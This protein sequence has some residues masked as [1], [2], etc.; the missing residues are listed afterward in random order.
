MDFSRRTFTLKSSQMHT[1]HFSPLIPP[2]FLSIIFFNVSPCLFFFGLAAGSHF[3]DQS[4]NLC[5]L[6]WQAAQ[7]LRHQGSP[8]L[9]FLNVWCQSF[10]LCLGYLG[11]FVCQKSA[12]ERQA[13]TASESIQ[14]GGR[15]VWGPPR[16]RPCGRGCQQSGSR[17]LVRGGG[18]WSVAEANPQG[19]LDSKSS[20][21]Q[22]NIQIKSF[23][24]NKQNQLENKTE[25][26]KIVITERN[27]V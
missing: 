11:S 26:S 27:K 18:S 21:P 7:P 6:H 13:P 4:S 19:V 23:H 1:H 14:E 24:R 15:S 16:V 5:P 17:K 10:I 2:L 8:R 12:G 3:P 20:A 25:D 22:S 9:V